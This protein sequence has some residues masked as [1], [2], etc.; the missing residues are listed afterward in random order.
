MKNISMILPAQLFGHCVYILKRDEPDRTVVVYVGSSE[1][2]V[3]RFSG[4]HAFPTEFKKTDY[5]E[6]IFCASKAEALKLEYT[7]IAEL[8]PLININGNPKKGWPSMDACSKSAKL[9]RRQSFTKRK[10]SL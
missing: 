4:H 9:E 6:M 1:H 5:V 7:L 8:Q 3:R 10:K 2:G